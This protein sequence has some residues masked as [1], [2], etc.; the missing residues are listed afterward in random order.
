MRASVANLEIRPRP[1]ARHAVNRDRL[2]VER[3]ALRTGDMLGL[4]TATITA[5]A[6]WCPVVAQYGVEKVG[7]HI[8]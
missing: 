1:I 8:F 7:V 6:G 5:A 3:A 4:K 2:D